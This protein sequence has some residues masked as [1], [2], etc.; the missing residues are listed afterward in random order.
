MIV[1]MLTLGCLGDFDPTPGSYIHEC[2]VGQHL[3][4]Q[5][6]L[7]WNSLLPKMASLVPTNMLMIFM[8]RGSWSAEF[9]VVQARALSSCFS[10]ERTCNSRTY[11]NASGKIHMQLPDIL[12]LR[13]YSNVAFT[14]NIMQEAA[15]TQARCLKCRWGDRESDG[16]GEF[17]TPSN[18][19]LS[20]LP[21]VGF[22]TD[23]W[24]S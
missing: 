12:F 11:T 4:S 1:L 21:V 10:S 17:N 14:Q 6:G 20:I 8:S 3:V 19:A 16:V 2:L 23:T 13:M 22:L 5:L 24:L 7:Y 15:L 18:N 9:T